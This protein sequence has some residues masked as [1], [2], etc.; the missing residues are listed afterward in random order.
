MVSDTSNRTNTGFP[1]TKPGGGAWGHVANIK[2]AHLA[3]VLVVSL[4]FLH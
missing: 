4:S 2:C 3:L 1:G